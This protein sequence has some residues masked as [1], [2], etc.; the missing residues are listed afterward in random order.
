M[1]E[2][3]T[4]SMPPPDQVD[5]AVALAKVETIG[6]DLQEIK[7]SMKE[8][9]SAVSKL[10]VVE[11]RQANLIDMVNRI[12]KEVKKLEERVQTIEIAQPIQKQSSDYVQSAV[13]YIIAA[14]LGAIVAGYL[15]N[16]QSVP[17]MSHPAITG[18]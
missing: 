9:A 5:V 8:L 6:E 10:A 12:G 2:T 7:Q 4:P 11:E 3:S 14:V 16:N 18:K 17:P 13:K 15:G 1:N